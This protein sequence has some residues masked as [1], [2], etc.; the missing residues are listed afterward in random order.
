[1]LSILISSLTGL[2]FGLG[3]L[4]YLDASTLFLSAILLALIASKNQKAVEI[5]D[6][7]VGMFFALSVAPAIGVS[8]DEVVKLQNGFVMQAL[9]SFAFFLYFYIQKPSIIARL[10]KSQR[11]TLGIMLSSTIAGFAAGI[12]SALCWQIYL[13]IAKSL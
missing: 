9:L 5:S 13:Q 6:K 10:Q 11:A 1:M 7:I 8:I 2:I 12:M 4:L 3:I